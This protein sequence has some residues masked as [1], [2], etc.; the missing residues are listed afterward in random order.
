MFISVDEKFTDQ[1]GN[2][3]EVENPVDNHYITYL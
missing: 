2:T 1:A 3:Y